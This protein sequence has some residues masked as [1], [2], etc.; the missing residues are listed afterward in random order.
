MEWTYNNK[1]LTNFEKS[2]KI[3]ANGTIW[4]YNTIGENNEISNI[5]LIWENKH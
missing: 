4:W 3:V 2:V 5:Q 1:T